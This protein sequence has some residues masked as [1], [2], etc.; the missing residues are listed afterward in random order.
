[1]EMSKFRFLM[2]VVT[3]R[4]WLQSLSL[5]HEL[6]SHKYAIYDGPLQASQEPMGAFHQWTMEKMSLCPSLYFLTWKT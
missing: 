4:N 6:T 5:D 2:E 3:L 1:M